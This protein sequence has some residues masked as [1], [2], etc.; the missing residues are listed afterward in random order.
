MVFS[1]LA[2]YFYINDKPNFTPSFAITFTYFYFISHIIQFWKKKKEN[3]T[4]NNTPFSNYLKKL[5]LF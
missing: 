2:L 1:L 4:T 3:K 5:S